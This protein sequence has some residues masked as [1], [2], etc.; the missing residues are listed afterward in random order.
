MIFLNF[1]LRYYKSNLNM[2][3]M[4][5]LKKNICKCV[6]FIGDYWC[7]GVDIGERCWNEEGDMRYLWFCVSNVWY[8]KFWEEFWF[9]ND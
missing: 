5:D 9:R 4:I 1:V 7:Y 3:L 8:E 6:F 2:I